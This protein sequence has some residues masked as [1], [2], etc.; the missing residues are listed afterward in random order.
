VISV[1]QAYAILRGRRQGD[2]EEAQGL[3]DNL[4]PEA[5]AERNRQDARN[6]IVKKKKAYRLGERLRRG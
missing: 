6:R 2:T 5:V 4:S 1:A 3:L